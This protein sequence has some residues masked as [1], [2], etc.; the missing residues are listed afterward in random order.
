MVRLQF[1]SSGVLPN[2]Y[3]QVH[4]EYKTDLDE[5]NNGSVS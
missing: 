5:T 2:Y 1:C 4:T 3:S